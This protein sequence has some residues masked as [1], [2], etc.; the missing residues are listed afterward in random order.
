MGHPKTINKTPNT[1]P[2]MIKRRDDRYVVKQYSHSGSERA[3]DVSSSKTV[4]GLVGL[5]ESKK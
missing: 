2:I 1:I 5:L 4:D 3:V